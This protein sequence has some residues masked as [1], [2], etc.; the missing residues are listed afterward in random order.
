MEGRKHPY[1][2]KDIYNSIKEKD[3]QV[4][5]RALHAEENAFLQIVKYGEWVV[6][7]VICLQQQAHV[8]YVQEG[9]SIRYKNYLLY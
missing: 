1:C 5:T 6:K 3:N 7:V 8:S 4:Y 9:F 2:F